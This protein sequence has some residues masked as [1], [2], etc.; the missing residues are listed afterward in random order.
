MSVYIKHMMGKM[1]CSC[2]LV[3]T[4]LALQAVL[5]TRGM[6]PFSST[7]GGLR[8]GAAQWSCSVELAV[9]LLCCPPP[10]EWSSSVQPSVDEAGLGV[11]ARGW[12]NIMDCKK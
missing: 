9:A 1:C 2:V 4:L 5:T 3:N 10:T 12:G 6:R 11:R 7:Y 8:G